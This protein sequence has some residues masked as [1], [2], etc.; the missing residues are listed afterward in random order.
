MN[1]TKVKPDS[2]LEAKPNVDL[3]NEDCWQLFEEGKDYPVIIALDKD[4]AIELAK[5]WNRCT[6]QHEQNRKHYEPAIE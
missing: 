3:I 2:Y 6:M 1:M 4:F 5:R